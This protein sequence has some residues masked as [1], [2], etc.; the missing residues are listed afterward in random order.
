M[1]PI[2]LGFIP[3]PETLPSSCE[4]CGGELAGIVLGWLMKGGPMSVQRAATCTRCEEVWLEQ[5]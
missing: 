4:D 5:Q 3:V 1:Y 2:V